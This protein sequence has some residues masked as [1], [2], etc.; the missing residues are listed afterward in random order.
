MIKNMVITESA[1]IWNKTVIQEMYDL[2]FEI[3]VV[4]IAIQKLMIKIY[5]GL[6][7]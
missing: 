3:C 1:N 7:F 6:F 5:L 4:C 2:I